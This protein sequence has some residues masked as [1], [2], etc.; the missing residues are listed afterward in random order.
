MSEYERIN[1]TLPPELKA[2]AKDRAQRRGFGTVS[3]Y[4]RALILE[5][6]LV[7]DGHQEPLADPYKAIPAGP[8]T[9]EMRRAFRR[10]AGLE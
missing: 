1:I 10:K 6:R 9:E 4:I 8:W 2:Y 3:E 5:D 7:D